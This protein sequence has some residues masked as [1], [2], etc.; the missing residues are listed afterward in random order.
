MKSKLMLLT[1]LIYIP[2]LICA[3]SFKES[4]F[5]NHSSKRRNLFCH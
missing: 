3:H 4:A 2:G 1:F 5:F